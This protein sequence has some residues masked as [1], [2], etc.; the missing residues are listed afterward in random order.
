M[1][2]QCIARPLT[3]C[4]LPTIGILFSAWQ[5]IMQA[6]QPVQVF[7]STAMPHWF[8]ARRA[9]DEYK[10]RTS[11]ER[12]LARQLR[13]HPHFLREIRL[14]LEFL[15]R[16][17]AHQGAPF[18]AVV[19]LGDGETVSLP[20]RFDHR[21]RADHKIRLCRGAQRIDIHAR[22]FRD[23][24][25]DPAPVTEREGNRVVRVTGSDQHGD[26]DLA[27]FIDRNLDGV[28]VL[29]CRDIP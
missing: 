20:V 1:R 4:S 18:H 8:G 11:A 22:A 2:I 26:L 23:A 27:V 12:F 17:F 28:E 21:L 13:V 16:G 19:L 9:A 6:L 7:R 24:S 5:A 3:T 14:L 29:L 25:V 10:A 15:K